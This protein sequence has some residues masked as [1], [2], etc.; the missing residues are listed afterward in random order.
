MAA[1]AAGTLEEAGW[2]VGATSNANSQD[3]PATIIYY[4]DASLEGAALGVVQ[5]LPGATILLAD[6]FVDSGA[7]LTVV[8]GNDYVAPPE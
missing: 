6:D 5:S 4:A 2:T 1:S 7:D 3:Q 8:I